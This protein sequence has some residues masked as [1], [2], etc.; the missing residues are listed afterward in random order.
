MT[1]PTTLYNAVQEC[2]TSISMYVISP[3]KV[4]F[5]L[6]NLQDI[7]IK[8]ILCSV[9]IHQ[10]LT[11]LCGKISHSSLSWLCNK[12]IGRCFETQDFIWCSGVKQVVNPQATE[13]TISKQTTQNEAY[14]E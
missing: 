4:Q 7:S 13:S 2:Q 11:K 14:S 12:K 9:K 5:G 6:T 8:I 10:F 1:N 3:E